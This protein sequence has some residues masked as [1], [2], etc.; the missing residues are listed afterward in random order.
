MYNKAKLKSFVKTGM[1]KNNMLI[2][3]KE[4][5]WVL[6]GMAM[7]TTRDAVAESV[8]QE[9]LYKQDKVWIRDEVEQESTMDFS[10]VIES[11]YCDFPELSITPYIKQKGKVL[12]RVFLK[13][14]GETSFC[15]QKYLDILKDFEMYRFT[16][17][18]SISPIYVLRDDDLIALIL[19]IR[20]SE[21]DYTVVSTKVK[22]D[23]SYDLRNA[24]VPF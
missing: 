9:F 23:S 16:Q 21:D 10:R 5:G 4:K 13:P 6:D 1:R 19:P 15:D 3:D 20:K 14:D 18:K 17:N 2:M 7:Y 24:D 12:M 22:R 11:G 8:L